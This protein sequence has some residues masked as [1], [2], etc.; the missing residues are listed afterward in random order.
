MLSLTV[1][2][3]FSACRI[4]PDSEFIPSESKTSTSKVSSETSKSVSVSSA[5]KSVSES[6]S[7]SIHQHVFD[8]KAV[9]SE[10]IK[11]AT[12]T[13]LPGECYFSCECGEKGT[14]TFS[15]GVL[16][17]DY[18]QIDSYITYIL[19]NG[20]FDNPFWNT[21]K[22]GSATWNYIDGCMMTSFWKLYDQTKDEKYWNFVNEF[23]NSLISSDGS[24]K[25][26]STRDYNL[27][28]INEGRILFDMYAKKGSAKYK[29]ALDTLY[30]QL[31]NQPRTSAE[32]KGNFWHKKRY[33]EQI[34][35]DGIY[36]AQP[37]YA[38]Y[39]KTF[40]TPEGQ[41]PD[42]SDIM[43]QIANVE[44]YMKDKTTG[45]YYHGI[46]VSKKQVWADDTTGLS[47]NYWLRATGWY[48]AA[49][50]DLTDI[51]DREQNPNE[52][53]TVQ[54]YLKGAVDAVLPYMDEKTHMFYQVIDR[55]T[56]GIP[57]TDKNGKKNYLETSGT[58][59]IAYAILNG[60]NT[61]A[62]DQSYYDIGKGIFN[63]I[64]ENKLKTSE[65]GEFVLT[66]ICK[67]AGL[68]SDRDGSFEYYLSE[69]IVKNEAK[70]VAPFLMAY[71]EILK[72]E[73]T[74]A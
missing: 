59:L 51:I 33:T 56:D 44:K 43:S 19:E 41:T 2:L 67:V 27:D 26:Y 25:G 4:I 61:G 31:K 18:T 14:E 63:G 64:C 15:T 24:M 73:S 12:T 49:L 57:D 71:V 55:V 68:S 72:A 8:K 35:L 1:I 40:L 37:F 10:Y 39:I 17:G 58:A 7:E 38:R 48:F 23:M 36:M 29:T 5:D 70:G 50:S 46:D 52:W 74:V 34:W 65:S 62:L 28:N 69:P 3:S 20:S 16:D 11:T 66:D 47:P 22:S 54:G 42:Y 60:A 30:N 53:A 13:L 21:E 6:K 45:L 9:K 32:P